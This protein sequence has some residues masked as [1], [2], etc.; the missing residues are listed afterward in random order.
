LAARGWR[1]TVDGQYGPESQ[2]VCRQFQQAN[3]LQVDGIVGAAT[4]RAAW[5]APVLSYPGRRG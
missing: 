2:A 5:T 1:I 3:G 4:W